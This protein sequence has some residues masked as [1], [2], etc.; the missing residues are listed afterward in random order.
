MILHQDFKELLELLD[1]NQVEYLIVG[2][3][4][5]GFYGN[6]RTTGDIDIWIDISKENARQMVK[7][8]EEFGISSLG[9]SEK[10][11]MDKDVVVQIGVVPVR[12]DILTGISG[13]EFNEAY[14]NREEKTINEVTLKYLSREDFIKN[15][16][17]SG[18]KKDLADIETI[19]TTRDKK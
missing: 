14:K 1:K 17:A 13:V 5:L 9:Y 19:L 12:I 4:A 16:L 8:F 10:D 18:R 6:P 3:F 15:K 11:F 2:A 7:T